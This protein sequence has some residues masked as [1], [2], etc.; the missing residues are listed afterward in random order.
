MNLEVLIQ[1]KETNPKKKKKKAGENPDP[2]CT[3]ETSVH[4]FS[5]RLGFLEA[6]HAITW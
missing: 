6:I 5:R 1:H 4:Y 2:K 3:R